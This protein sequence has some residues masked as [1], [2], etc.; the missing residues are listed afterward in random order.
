MPNFE[1]FTKKAT[2]T[3]TGP[4]VSIQRGGVFSLNAEA[5]ALLGNCTRTGPAAVKWMKGHAGEQYLAAKKASD[6]EQSFDASLERMRSMA[7]VDST[8]HR[9]EL[10]R[11]PLE[12]KVQAAGTRLACN[13]IRPCSIGISFA[14]PVVPDVE[15]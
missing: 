2:R 12:K 15:K 7:L 14:S 3:G 10:L 5:Y 9:K 6:L 8:A 4:L 1:T 13:A 11:L